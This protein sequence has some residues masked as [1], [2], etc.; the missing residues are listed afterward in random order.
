MSELLE[1]E[2]EAEAFYRNY[3]VP[4]KHRDIITKYFVLVGDEAGEVEFF[5]CRNCRRLFTVAEVCTIVDPKFLLEHPVKG[6]DY[7]RAEFGKP[8]HWQHQCNLGE[9]PDVT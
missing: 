8:W 5:A 1:I 6:H 3:K 7:I 9:V 2:G 4:Q